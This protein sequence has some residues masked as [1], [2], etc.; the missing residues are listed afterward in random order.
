MIALGAVLRP[1]ARISYRK[2]RTPVVAI[3]GSVGKTTTKEF[4]AKVLA[5]EF[6]VRHT[7]GNFNDRPGVMTTVLGVPRIRRIFDLVR[8]L[9]RVLQRTIRPRGADYLV[10]EISAGHIELALTVFIP[11]ISVVTAI[12]PVHL[13]RFGSIEGIIEE[14]SNLVRGLPENGFAVLCFDDRAVRAMAGLNRG[15][16]VFYGFSPEADVWMDEPERVNGGFATTLHDG[17]YEARLHFPHLVNRFHLLAVMAAWCVG[18]IA[19]IPRHRMRDIVQQLNPT[20]G[21]GDV[22]AGPR[23]SLL[24]NDSFSA[25]PAAMKASLETFQAVAGD[26]R[27]FLVLGEMRELGPDE[28]RFH[29]E[30]GRYSAGS[31]DILIAVGERADVYVAEFLAA[32]PSA[33]AFHSPDAS[34]AFSI[35]ERELREG[36]AILFK[37]SHAVGL[38][39]LIDRVRAMPQ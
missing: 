19:G 27:R 11:F 2:H 30:V 15:S 38:Q 33:P 17:S 35:L 32:H 8:T 5:S 31:G 13:E 14:K 26:R 21:R 12:A 9:P 25:S 1:F 39:D 6:N 16:T 28:E 34:S 3:T 37:G 24:I 7:A 20:K 22:S 18:S 29:R 10:I 4:V 36:D 23:G